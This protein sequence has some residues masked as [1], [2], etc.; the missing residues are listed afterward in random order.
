MFKYLSVLLLTV[1]IFYGCDSGEDTSKTEEE[2]TLVSKRSI[3][4]KEP[5]DL[6]LSYDK[7]SLWTVSDSTGNIYRLSLNGDVE[8]ELAI[9]GNDP[10]G[11]AVI[12]SQVHAVVFEDKNHIVFYDTSGNKLKTVNIDLCN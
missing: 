11:I 8:K 6:A 4:V 10:E 2:F 5:S 9:G 3:N 1:I 12:N 7:K